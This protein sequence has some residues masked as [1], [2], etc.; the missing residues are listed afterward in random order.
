LAQAG[1]A[2]FQSA[3]AAQTRPAI[4]GLGLLTGNRQCGRL[5]TGA[6]PGIQAGHKLRC[7]AGASDRPMQPCQ[8]A[9][10][11]FNSADL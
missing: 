5:E 9:A 3:N 8:P 10:V 11:G 1:N 6:T 2:D 7:A 4:L